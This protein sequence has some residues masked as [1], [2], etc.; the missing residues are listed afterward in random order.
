MCPHVKLLLDRALAEDLP[1]LAGMLLVN[2]CDA[3]RRLADAWALARPKDRIWSFDLPVHD[4]PGA[5][6]FLAGELAR[7][8]EQ[9]QAAG[10]PRPDPQ[11]VLEHSRRYDRLAHLLSEA[12]RH[13]AELQA[14]PALWQEQANLAVTTP[15][16]ESL[17]RLEALLAAP[18][19]GAAASGVPVLLIGNVLPQVGAIELF[20]AAGL[21][22]VADDLCTGSRQLVPYRLPDAA[23]D[24]ESTM[25]LELARA[26]LA[27]PPCGRTF[28]PERPGRLAELTVARAREAGARGVVAHVMKFCD[29]Y[30]SRLPVVQQALKQAG[31]GYLQL[32]GDGSL[33]SLGQQRTRLEA[34][35][36]M[37][38]A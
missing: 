21:R 35:A 1:D 13:L 9:L 12:R 20:A 36:E 8:I 34:F 15:L 18:P 31:L 32:E 5:A 17:A 23:A 29:P 33:K 10:H 26:L 25:L 28:S 37:M 14:G 3:M 2:S 4:G 22:L 38:G 30:L 7:L 24:S 11:E 6:E 19:R 27:R 16:E